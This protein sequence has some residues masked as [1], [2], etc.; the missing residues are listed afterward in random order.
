MLREQGAK[1]ISI[2]TGAYR[3]IATAYTLKLASEARVDYVTFDGYEG[4]KGMNSIPMIAEAAAV[5]IRFMGGFGFRSSS[6]PRATSS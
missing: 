4:G 5:A 3:P 1:C 2:K 6:P